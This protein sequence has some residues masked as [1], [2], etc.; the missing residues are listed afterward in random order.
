MKILFK[1]KE[2][3]K[4]ALKRVIDSG[5]LGENNPGSFYEFKPNIWV[6][7]PVSLRK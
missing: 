7:V 6:S 4:G 5:I 1:T 2:R 3:T